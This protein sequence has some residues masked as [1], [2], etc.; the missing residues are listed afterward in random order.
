MKEGKGS[1]RGTTR[2]K[3]R[4]TGEKQEKRERT[5]VSESQEGRPLTGVVLKEKKNIAKK[6]WKRKCSYE[7]LKEEKC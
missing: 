3:N 7:R 2:G 6:G 5:N 1:G 4:K